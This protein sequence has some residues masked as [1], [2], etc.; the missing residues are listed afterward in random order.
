MN[1]EVSDFFPVKP[2]FEVHPFPEE[3]REARKILDLGIEEEPVVSFLS[4]TLGLE[5]FAIPLS[6]ARQV[7]RLAEVTPVPGT[8]HYIIGVI[9][10]KSAIYPLID[11]HGLLNL[12]PQPLTRSSRF[13]IVNPKEEPFAILVDA[14]AEVKVLEER[15]L[16]NQETINLKTPG[17]I[18]KRILVEGRNVGLINL[19]VVLQTVKEEI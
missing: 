12:E 15:V 5:W 17:L 16:E 13:L 14:M 2:V 1:G 18:S 11:I 4:F 7:R 19:E 3:L 6:S 10:H 8:N 9:N